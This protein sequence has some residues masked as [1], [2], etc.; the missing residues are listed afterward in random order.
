MTLGSP[1]VP[2][3]KKAISL[4]YS[5]FECCVASVKKS[6]IFLSSIVVII[7]IFCR[8]SSR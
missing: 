5:T 6:L 7:L 2:E 1:V 8:I 4:A 3:D